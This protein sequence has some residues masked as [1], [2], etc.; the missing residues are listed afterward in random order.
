MEKKYEKCEWVC[1]MIRSLD[2]NHTYIGSSN[3]PRNRLNNHN[4]SDKSIK[5]K[6]AV[7]TSGQT[8]IPVLIVS[9]FI[10]KIAC[11]SFEAG[12]KRLAKTRKNDKNK[13]IN[14][15]SNINLQY[16][17]DPR[18]NRIIDLLF[19]TNNFTVINDKF[20]ANYKLNHAIIQPNGLLFIN[21][22]MESWLKDLPWPSFVKIQDGEY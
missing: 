8:W 19:F 12:W 14:N 6:G 2:T 4:N 7:R 17:K 11:L 22:F 3:N 1:Y 16:T 13:K 20:A 15:I 21:T 18:I 9:G 10:S 5:R